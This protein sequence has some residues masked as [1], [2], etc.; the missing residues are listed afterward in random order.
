MRYVIER[1]YTDTT[2]SVFLSGLINGVPTWGGIGRLDGAWEMPYEMAQQLTATL[3]AAGYEVRILN[4][5]GEPP[6]F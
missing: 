2:S 4:D 6:H 3:K 5:E 1:D